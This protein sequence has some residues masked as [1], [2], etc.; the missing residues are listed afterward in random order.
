MLKLLSLLVAGSAASSTEVSGVTD[1]NI[2]TMIAEYIRR[3]SPKLSVLRGVA[4]LTAPPDVHAELYTLS[5]LMDGDAAS[6]YAMALPGAACDIKY[7]HRVAARLA[8]VFMRLRHVCHANAGWS[9]GPFPATVR[10][11]AEHGL[12]QWS[13][14]LSEANDVDLTILCGSPE[15]VRQI[16][17]LRA[18]QIEFHTTH[19]RMMQWVSETIGSR[20]YPAAVIEGI[21]QLQRATAAGV[22]PDA[23]VD[24]VEAAGAAGRDTS[25]LMIQL[26]TGVGSFAKQLNLALNAMQEARRQDGQ[27]AHDGMMSAMHERGEEWR[28]ISRTAKLLRVLLVTNGLLVRAEAA[29]EASD[30]PTG[31]TTGR[32]S[33][34]DSLTPAINE[35]VVSTCDIE[36]TSTSTSTAVSGVI[37]S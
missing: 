17:C 7:A 29:Q 36:S 20:H 31:V 16:D 9:T 33:F 28:G 13:S 30:S 24:S 27:N 4:S 11:T 32:S 25:D 34:D 2:C 23:L 8:R 6:I 15:W 12:A 26:L 37:V 3:D 5:A 1:T 19:E 10:E 22:I 14:L 35:M 18:T 21:H